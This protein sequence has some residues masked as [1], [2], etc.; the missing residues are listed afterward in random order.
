MEKIGVK[1]EIDKLGRICIAIRKKAVQNELPLTVLLPVLFFILFS[2]DQ[3]Q[4][5]LR[6]IF[7][8]PYK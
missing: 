2:S 5:H 3:L 1:K 7:W 4:E 6:Q 8:R